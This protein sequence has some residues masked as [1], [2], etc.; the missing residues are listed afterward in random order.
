VLS[1][2]GIKIAPSTYYEYLHRAAT[3]PTVGEQRDEFLKVEIARVHK[4]NFV[5]YGARKVWLQ[6]NREGICVARCTVERLM[7]DLGLVG[8]VRGKVKKTTIADPDHHRADDLVGRRFAPLAPDRLW[9]C[10][11][12]YVSTWSGWVYVAFVTDAYARRILGWRAGTTMS[13]Q[14]TLDAIEQAIW[15][16]QRAG[17]DGTARA[18]G[19]GSL[20]SVVA[21]SDRGS[22]YTALKY[23]ER[24]AEAGIAA[25]VGSVGDSYDN[26]L[27]ETINGLYKTELIKARGPWKT[28]D[29]V[30]YATAEWVD[31]FNHRR[32]YQY[33]G[34]I[35]PAELEAAYYAQTNLT[36]A[37]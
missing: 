19:S 28:L 12:T 5:V 8:V 29:E 32:L 35:P 11:L 15:T 27:A 30:E 4:A 23:G 9:V 31:W 25:S 16:R 33:C 17:T 1:E 10:D 6:L 22:Q 3:G 26:A 18:A 24:L 34:D 2:H 21:H 14:L 37:G 36:P 13:T 20:E 7:R